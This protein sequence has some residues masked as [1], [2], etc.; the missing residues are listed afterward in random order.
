[1]R[2]APGARRDSRRALAWIPASSHESIDAHENS[3]EARLAA[4]RGVLHA[5]MPLVLAVVLVARHPWGKLER[6]ASSAGV[7]SGPDY[8]GSRCSCFGGFR[9]FPNDALAGADTCRI[10]LE[11]VSL[12]L[13]DTDCLLDGR[14]GGIN[15]TIFA[16]TP[17]LPGGRRLLGFRRRNG[18]AGIPAGCAPTDGKDSRL[19]DRLAPMGGLALYFANGRHTA[20]FGIAA[21]DTD[22]HRRCGHIRARLVDGT[23]G[24]APGGGSLP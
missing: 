9:C 7:Q 24:L 17:V 8:V 20:G 18:L 13:L 11:G 4:G 5:G 22:S 3:G 16:E 10:V 19:S 12:L 6:V 2:I 1:M 23:H 15:E 21:G 14:V